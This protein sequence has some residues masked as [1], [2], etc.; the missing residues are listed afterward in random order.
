MRL[1]RCMPYSFFQRPVDVI[2]IN[3][4]QVINF[5]LSAPAVFNEVLDSN[6]INNFDTLS[7]LH[8]FCCCW[9]FICSPTLL[10]NT[11]KLLKC[12]LTKLFNK[13]LVIPS[14]PKLM[15]GMNSTK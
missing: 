8:K 1:A 11:K 4:F 14:I 13:K 7:V 5:L 12:V 9:I 10:L 6:G 3:R 2:S 15:S